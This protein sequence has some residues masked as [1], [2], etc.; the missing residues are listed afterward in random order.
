MKK[1]ETLNSIAVLNGTLDS[2]HRGSGDKKAIELVT[3]K[4]LKLVE[5]L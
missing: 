5:K 4:I 1:Q 3:K 2:L